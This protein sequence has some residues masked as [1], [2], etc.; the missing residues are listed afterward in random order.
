MN[1]T[2]K[3]SNAPLRRCIVSGERLEKKQLLRLVRTPLGELV[4]D[5][6]GKRN[7]RGA[8][9]KRDL[10][11]VDRLEA[12]SLLKRHLDVDAHPSFYD[13]LREVIR[14]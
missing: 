9:I 3:K 10:T 14:G 4:I 2:T 7:G 12:S 8:Y 6:T 1:I 5:V 13:A 11:I